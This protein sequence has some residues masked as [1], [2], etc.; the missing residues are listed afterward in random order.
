MWQNL[1]V[2]VILPHIWGGGGK[3]SK[4]WSCFKMWKRLKFK[5]NKLLYASQW[6]WL[7]IFCTN[8]IPFH[9][10]HCVEPYMSTDLICRTI[11]LM[12]LVVSIYAFEKDTIHFK[13]SQINLFRSL[14]IWNIRWIKKP[15]FI[16]STYLQHTKHETR[17]ILKYK[18]K[19][20]SFHEVT[21]CPDFAGHLQVYQPVVFGLTH[22]FCVQSLTEEVLK[23]QKWCTM[24]ICS[25]NSSNQSLKILKPAFFCFKDLYCLFC[26]PYPFSCHSYAQP[27]LLY[28]T[29]LCILPRW[30]NQ[31]C[32]CYPRW[33]L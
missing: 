5:I 14:T 12:L 21:I 31:K 16:N 20:I 30:E 10:Y 1:A 27:L 33:L 24:V 6:G 25:R 28:I 7:L 2:A 8:P 19:N 11:P 32:R 29:I 4:Q 18:T 23:R 3:K 17:T 22:S 15:H 9:L 13:S 26:S